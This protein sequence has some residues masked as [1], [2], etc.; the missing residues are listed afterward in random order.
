MDEDMGTDVGAPLSTIVESPQRETE[1][2]SPLLTPGTSCRDLRQFLEQK[3]VHKASSERA[4]ADDAPPPGLSADVQE[5]L[6]RRLQKLAGH[7]HEARQQV[8][9]AFAATL[10]E[11]AKVVFSEEAKREAAHRTQLEEWGSS[12]AAGCVLREEAMAVKLGENLADI[13]DE[14]RLGRDSME[15]L[16]QSFTSLSEE[17]AR[18]QEQIS[19][20]EVDMRKVSQRLLELPRQDFFQGS[21]ICSTPRK[22]FPFPAAGQHKLLR[23]QSGSP[24]RATIGALPTQHDSL[25]VSPAGVPVSLR[26]NNSPIGG[27]QSRQNLAAAGRSLELP[28]CNP[29]ATASATSPARTGRSPVLHGER[30]PSPET[31]FIPPAAMLVAPPRSHSES[32]LIKPCGVPGGPTSNAEEFVGDASVGLQQQTAKTWQPPVGGYCKGN[33][34]L[35]P[36]SIVGSCPQAGV[37]IKEACLLPN[38]LPVMLPDSSPKANGRHDRNGFIHPAMGPFKTSRSLQAPPAAAEIPSQTVPMVSAR[39]LAVSPRRRASPS[40]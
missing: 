27:L 13:A 21:S 24:S 12:I 10:E 17:V 5:Y 30:S 34:Y 22:D 16:A 3:L 8:I 28:R 14:A 2:V 7:E 25:T 32:S 40:P 19:S 35:T 26:R 38:G 9:G 37:P 15:G 11:W 23:P 31:N 29:Q 36:S 18:M 39:Y 20:L 6:D 4:L 33:D 1:E